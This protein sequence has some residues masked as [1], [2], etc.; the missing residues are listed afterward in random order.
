M[1]NSDKTFIAFILGAVAG[2]LTALLLAPESGDKTRKKINKTASD[3]LYD[4]EDAWES[5]TEKVK[6]LADTAIQELEKYSK[7][8]KQ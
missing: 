8:I 1:E 3:V 6:D 4:M 2:A 5:N 7:K